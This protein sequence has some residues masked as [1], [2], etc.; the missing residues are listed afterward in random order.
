MMIVDFKLLRLILMDFGCVQLFSM[1]FSGY[2]FAVGGFHVF[3]LVS[4]GLRINS[5]I[6]QTSINID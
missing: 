3:R 2:W 6:W 4:T 5:W 1:D